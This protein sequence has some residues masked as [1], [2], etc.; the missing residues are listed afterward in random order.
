MPPRRR[1]RRTALV[2]FPLPVYTP[3]MGTNMIG[4]AE[5][6]VITAE[7]RRTLSEQLHER[8]VD[9]IICG[10]ISYGDKLNIKQLAAEFGVSPMPM[11][12]AIKRLEQEGVVVVKPRSNCYV[13][14]P[15]KGM[16]LDAIEARRMVEVFAATT[17]CD[18]AEKADTTTLDEILEAMRPIAAHHGDS[19]R[20]ELANHYIE[21]DRRFHTNLVALARNRYLDR[22]YRQIGLHLNMNLSYGIGVCH[23]I[24]ATFGEHQAILGALQVGSAEAARILERHLLQSRENILSDPTYQALPD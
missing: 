12:D 20:S 18:Q 21:L 4:I 7:T 1:A 13:R 22:L 8:L 2:A 16:V 17:V 10:E 23:G 14:K 6:P 11:R 3:G 19:R 5:P 15:T 9:R 24:E